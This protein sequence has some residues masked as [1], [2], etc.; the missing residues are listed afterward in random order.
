MSTEE[1]DDL[2][3]EDDLDHLAD[4]EVLM[5]ELLKDSQQG[6]LKKAVSSMLTTAEE[7]VGELRSLYEKKPYYGL[8]LAGCIGLAL[9]LAVS[10]KSE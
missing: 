5:T 8:F 10:R 6:P 3:A 4:A 1:Q 7:G 2:L 9:G